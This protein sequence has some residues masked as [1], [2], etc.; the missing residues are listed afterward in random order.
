MRRIK[1]RSFQTRI[2]L[3]FTVFIIIFFLIMVGVLFGAIYNL[4]R[5]D[6]EKR[7]GQTQSLLSDSI[8]RTK[9]NVE[10][11][12]LKLVLEPNL[13]EILMEYDGQEEIH[14]GKDLIEE[15]SY[16]VDTNPNIEGCDVITNSGVF[17]RTSDY[18][19]IEIRQLLR[20]VQDTDYRSY[21]WYGPYSVKK[22]NG[23]VESIFVIRKKIISSSNGLE[24]GEVFTYVSEASINE[25]LQSAENSLDTQYLVLD[26]SNYII[27]PTK[28]QE[29]FS[30][31]RERVVTEN[32]QEEFYIESRQGAQFIQSTEVDSDEWRVISVTSMSS[33][34]QAFESVQVVII[35]IMIIGIL[36]ILIA[37]VRIS[38]KVTEP[39]HT[40]VDTMEQISEGNRELRLIM[41]ENCSEE[42]KIV[43][44]SFNKLMNHNEELIK[45]VFEKQESIRRYSFLLLQEQIKPHFMYNSLSTISALVK[46]KMNDEAVETV[47]NLA[48]FFRTTLNGG[49]HLYTLMEEKNM[50][51]N[52]LV[53]QKYR[54]HGKIE[55]NIE[56]EEGIGDQCVPKLTLQPLVENAIYHGVKGKARI[57]RI[58]IKGV[59]AADWVYLSVKDEGV[60][61]AEQKIAEILENIEE[62]NQKNFGLT[63]VNQRLKMIYEKDYSINIRSEVGQYTIVEMKIP[64][65]SVY[66]DDAEYELI[67]EKKYEK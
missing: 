60:G 40:M 44:Q 52:Y 62:D 63:C 36:V 64:Y 5:E 29:E 20:A 23:I 51:E 9:E 38:K 45:D 46:L 65:R 57:T 26:E 2:Q 1:K 50:V 12:I 42:F 66:T 49:K 56:V 10:S 55:Y 35:F 53:V 27:A 37:T 3:L 32:L 41:K 11:D 14:V 58:E 33:L 67:A 8:N 59:R 54:Y 34:L 31:V 16:I 4:Y 48:S 61:I 17:I 13:Q 6:S 7:V 43:E 21:Q 24:Q 39:I 22:N 47:D 19:E 15:I 28:K 18:I 30:Y 25:I